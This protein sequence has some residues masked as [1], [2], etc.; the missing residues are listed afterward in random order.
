M[1]Y[2]SGHKKPS[3]S[4]KAPANSKKSKETKAK[5]VWKKVGRVALTVFL[6]FVITVTLVGCAAAIYVIN[7]VQPRKF[8]LGSANLDTTTILYANNIKTQKPEETARVNGQKN[9]IWV[10]GNQIPKNVKNAFVAIEDQRFYTHNGVDWKR[11][12][13]AAFNLLIPIYS[14]KQGGSTITQ[15]LINNISAADKNSNNYGRKI[16]EIVDAQQ[17]EKD[18]PDKDQIITAYLNTI[19]LNEGCYGVQTASEN[20]FGKDVKDL[21]LAEAA[22]LACLPRAPSEYDPRQH[23]DANTKRRKLVL[24][25][26]LDQKMITKAEYDKAINEKVKTV[27]KEDTNTRGWFEDHAVVEVRDDLM[28][29][30]GW[31]KDYALNVIYTK[32]LRIYTTENQLV[33]KSMDKVYTGLN[34]YQCWTQYKGAALGTPQSGMMVIDYTGQVV[35]V[36]GGNGEKKGNFVLDRTVATTRS[37]GSSIK[38]LAVYGPAIELDKITWSSLVSRSQI[39]VGGKLW[40]RNDDGI[41]YDGSQTVA[42]GLAQSRN[43][44]AVNIMTN[45]LTPD[46]SF[47]FLK[48]KLG[49]NTLVDRQKV[50]GLIKTDRTLSLSIGAL[51]NGVT[52]EEMCGG[53]QIFGNGGKYFKPHCYSKVTDSQGNVLLQNKVDG[54]Q[55]MTAESAFVMNKLLQS[56]VNWTG[57]GATC[58]KARINGVKV[59]GKTGTTNEDWD[60][61]FCG[62]TPD[63]VGCVWVGYEPPKKIPGYE[64][65]S[66]P[67]LL[68]WK[69][70]MDDIYS[71]MK[72]KDDY[73]T[74]GN[75]AEYKYDPT[76]GYVTDT[77][78]MSGWY[79]TNGVIPS[80]PVEPAAS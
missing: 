21:D 54:K 30:Y 48:N 5:R 13:G 12:A 18:Y 6:V 28:A 56:N 44:I 80:A 64:W 53:Y 22:S 3:R 73:P 39:T 50:N 52:I 42:E 8:D 27:E 38:P 51:T 4:N 32:G 65:L 41:G 47:D 33:Q 9:R 59:G 36:A 16:Q 1:S 55:A 10:E 69:S 61:W 24:K 26:M 75:V 17:L 71:Q 19:N 74:N 77:G 45:Y 72:S 29:K 78:S 67:S 62:I 43:T 11:T 35:G 7:F 49:F 31:T 14:S 25:N 58:G 63:F 60:R 15:Q 79:K 66:N 57:E 20:Y 40:P 76:T 23:Y 34:K 2:T 37:P 68:A 46:Y 70:V